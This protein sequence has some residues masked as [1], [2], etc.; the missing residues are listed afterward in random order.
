[1]N[2]YDVRLD[3]ARRAAGLLTVDQV[4]ALADRGVTVFDPFSTLVGERVELGEGCVLY[5]GTV[6]E[7]DAESACVLG[8]DNLLAPGTRI[9]AVHGGRVRIGDGN[10]LG[11]GGAQVKANRQDARIEIGDRTRISGGAEV[12]GISTLGDGCQVIGAIGAQSVTLEGG[13]DW[14]HPD[15]DARGAVLKGF[16]LARGLSLRVGDVVNGAGDFRAAAVERQIDYHPR[17]AGR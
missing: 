14:T 3:A 13:G 7:C 5:P 17:A 16:G 9:L 12:V 15:P 2:W 6:L 10:A 11:E 8:R 4:V 1:M